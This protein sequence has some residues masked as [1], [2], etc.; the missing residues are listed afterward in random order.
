MLAKETLLWWGWWIEPNKF[1]NR[2]VTVQQRG[3]D[4]IERIKISFSIL[5]GC[6]S[7][8]AIL[9]ALFTWS[10]MRLRIVSVLVCTFKYVGRDQ[11]QSSASRWTL[12]LD[13]LYQP[14]L[15]PKRQMRGSH[16]HSCWHRLQRFHSFG[17]AFCKVFSGKITCPKL[18]SVVCHM[19]MCHSRWSR[20]STYVHEARFTVQLWLS[21]RMTQ[22]QYTQVPRECFLL[23]LYVKALRTRTVWSIKMHAHPPYKY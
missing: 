9:H 17:L 3:M 20:M 15:V 5:P 16:L 18:S 1:V 19:Y 13:V 12:Q 8:T 14:F 21:L 4:Q 22:L 23:L 2:S 11:K 10:T 6:L 7:V